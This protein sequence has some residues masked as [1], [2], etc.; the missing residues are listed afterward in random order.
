MEK[1]EQHI[2]EYINFG[3]ATMCSLG[4]LGLYMALY[5]A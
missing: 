2:S 1:T 5:S 4:F 3:K